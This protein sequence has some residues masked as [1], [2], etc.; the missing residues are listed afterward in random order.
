MLSSVAD[1]SMIIIS[2]TACTYCYVLG[3]RLKGLQNTKDGLGAAI[4]AF[5]KSADAMTTTTKNTRDQTTQLV[6][7]LSTLMADAGQTCKEIEALTEKMENRHNRSL[8]EIS[9]AKADLQNLISKTLDEYNLR[10]KEFGSIAEQI[11]RISQVPTESANSSARVSKHKPI[12][13]RTVQT[14]ALRRKV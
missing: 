8:A 2:L 12:P 4:S 9:D 5:S 3:Q 14:D 6:E 7:H 1:L 13:L 11:H 10:I